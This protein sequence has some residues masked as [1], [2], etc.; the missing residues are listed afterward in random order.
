MPNDTLPHQILAFRLLK[1]SH[2]LPVHLHCEASLRSALPQLLLWMLRAQLTFF[3]AHI[4][5]RGARETEQQSAVHWPAN[6]I[7]AKAKSNP[8]SLGRHDT[9]A[10]TTPGTLEPGLL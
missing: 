10:L 2:T 5:I 7:I 3:L 9:L 1:L 8:P 6:E 4:Y